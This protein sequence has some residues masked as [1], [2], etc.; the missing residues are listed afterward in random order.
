MMEVLVEALEALETKVVDLEAKGLAVWEEV[1]A[2]GDMGQTLETWVVGA[3]V[4]LVAV[5]FFLFPTSP[6]SLPM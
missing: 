5:S 1:G 6:K 3:V 4:D 2:E